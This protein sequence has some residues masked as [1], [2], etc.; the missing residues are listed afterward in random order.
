MAMGRL[1]VRSSRSASVRRWTRKV[2]PR[3]GSRRRQRISILI[4]SLEPDP[5]Q[6]LDENLAMLVSE[7]RTLIAQK[8]LVDVRTPEDDL[9]ATGL[10]DS[11]SLIQLLSNLEEHFEIRIPLDELQIE[12]IR[13]IITIAR[14]VDRQSIHSSVARA[15]S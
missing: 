3:R 5:M 11:L 14:L 7:I 12:D 9:L 15:T 10:L 6:E 1:T 4:E 2:I 13:S 8:L